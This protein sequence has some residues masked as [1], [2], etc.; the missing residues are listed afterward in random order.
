MNCSWI[1]RWRQEDPT[2]TS[3]CSVY[4]HSCFWFPRSQSLCNISV[5]YCL[6]SVLQCWT[7]L[8]CD[9]NNFQA[10][11]LAAVAGTPVLGKWSVGSLPWCYR[12]CTGEIYMFTCVHTH[13]NSAN[14]HPMPS[15]KSHHIALWRSHKRT[16]YGLP[17]LKTSTTEA[18]TSRGMLL[19][20]LYLQKVRVEVRE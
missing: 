5:G 14:L 1:Q 7:N 13:A 6:C 4:L 11:W 12:I 19:V 8:I 9:S 17:E 2:R 20:R 15:N 3:G 16:R 10:P 18:R